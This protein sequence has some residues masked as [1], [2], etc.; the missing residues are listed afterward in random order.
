MLARLTKGAGL[1]ALVYAA[2]EAATLMRTVVFAHWLTPAQMGALVLMM[3]SLRLIE[4]ITDVSI[5]RLILQAKDGASVKF[6]TLAHGASI[7]RGFIGGLALL[8]LALPIA[9]TFDIN[10]EGLCFLAL[11][12]VIRGFFHLDCRIY[13]RHLKPGGAALAEGGGALAGLI[14]AWPSVMI[15]QGPEAIVLSSLAQVIVMVALS[16]MV[17][18]RKY[19][20]GLNTANLKRIWVFGWPLALNALFL[21][22]VFQGER[23]AVGGAYGLETLGR[24]GIASQLALIPALLAGRIALAGLLPAAS[25]SQARA[26]G[27]FGLG[28]LFTTFGAGLLFTACFALMAPGFINF[29]FGEHYALEAA[30][31][32]WLGAAAGARIARVGPVILLLANGDTRGVLA[33]SFLR[34]IALGVGILLALQGLSLVH[35]AAIAAA[36]EGASL[37]A[38]SLRLRHQCG[39]RRAI[40]PGLVI[41]AASLGICAHFIPLISLNAS[42]AMVLG[43]L[44]TGLAFLK[45]PQ[46]LK[47]N[48]LAAPAR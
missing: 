32:A 8:L 11:V 16:H 36:G 25:R 24:F 23:I 40:D 29:L 27:R 18:R 1:L 43:L 31:L 14:A 44:G 3:T 7:L 33:G 47:L 28:V 34:A 26:K 48:T 12:P 42:L 22:A 5:D 15:T 10:A 9:L 35:F 2:S 41:L 19:R 13:N 4:M 21:S 46:W 30:A 45:K 17:A 20:V 38:A 6:Q 39:M 37:I